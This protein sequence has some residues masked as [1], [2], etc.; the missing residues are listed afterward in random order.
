MTIATAARNIR[1]LVQAR[2]KAHKAMIKARIANTEAD[3]AT[4]TAATKL[5]N[6]IA[7]NDAADV[8]IAEYAKAQGCFGS[9]DDAGR[10]FNAY[11]EGKKQ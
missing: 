5:R 10:M 4:D 11:I 8:A 2:D 1:S 7:A 9:D 6:A 3:D